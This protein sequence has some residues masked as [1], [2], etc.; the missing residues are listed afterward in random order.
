MWEIWEMFSDLPS[1]AWSCETLQSGLQLAGGLPMELSAM[2][3]SQVAEL[4]A[5][6]AK[7]QVRV[8]K[9]QS[10]TQRRDQFF[11]PPFS[12]CFSKPKL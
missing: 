7:L 1:K 8:F 12:C 5:E 4:E 11:F 9:K 3:E 10:K 2:G 6:L